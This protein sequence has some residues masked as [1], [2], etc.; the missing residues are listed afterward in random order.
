MLAVASYAFR[1]IRW[2]GY[3]RLVEIQAST[4]L[5]IQI[6]LSGFAFTAS[7]GKTG[8]LM[9]AT[10][11]SHLGVPF[12]YNLCSFISERLLDVIIV[13]LLGAYFLI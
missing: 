1:S 5:H 7:P 8:E 12:K 11:L 2:L 3:L 13:L 10:H 4:V 6:Y 9:R